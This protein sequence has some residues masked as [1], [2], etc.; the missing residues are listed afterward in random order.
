MFRQ[1]A[2]VAKHLGPVASQDR[3]VG[4]GRR[5]DREGVAHGREGKNNAVRAR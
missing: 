2:H 3:R 5:P 1:N 4:D